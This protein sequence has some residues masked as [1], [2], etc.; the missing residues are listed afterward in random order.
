MPNA[1][2]AFFFVILFSVSFNIDFQADVQGFH[3]VFFNEI[4][5]YLHAENNKSF[6]VLQ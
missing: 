6:L 5:A 4:E 1:Y 3:M 2:N